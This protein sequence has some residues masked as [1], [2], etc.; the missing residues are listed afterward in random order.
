MFFG[1]S[2]EKE[3]E[4]SNLVQNLNLNL[5]AI[6][7]AN[8]EINDAEYSGDSYKFI[9]DYGIVRVSDKGIWIDGWIFPG[10]CSSFDE[11]VYLIKELLKQRGGKS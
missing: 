11:F 6:K 7:L 4:M 9:T 1:I 3:V 2:P 8:I 5:E 10:D